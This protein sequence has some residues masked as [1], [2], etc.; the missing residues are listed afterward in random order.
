M[1]GKRSEVACYHT[2]IGEDEVAFFQEVCKKFFVSLD[3][4][5]VGEG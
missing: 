2:V 1:K 4:L 3:V 5:S